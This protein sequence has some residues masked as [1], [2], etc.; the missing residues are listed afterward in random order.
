MFT[1]STFERIRI[2]DYTVTPFTVHKDFTVFKSEMSASGYT[3]RQAN[4]YRGNLPI[5]YKTVSVQNS[6]TSSD[7]TYN[8]INWRSIHNLYYSNPYDSVEG[9]EGY[10]QNACTKHLFLTASI[11]SAP[12]F[13]IGEGIKP[14]TLYLSS[15][16]YF[17]RDDKNNNLYDV[18]LTSRSLVDSTYLDAYWGFENLYPKTD[19]G[20]GTVQS[21]SFNYISNTQG[22]DITTVAHNVHLSPGVPVSGSNTGTKVDFITQGSYLFTRHVKQFNYET[23]ENFCISFWLK[24]PLSQSNTDSFTNTLINKNS[25][26]DFNVRI[27]RSKSQIDEYPNI[28][29][30][31][32]STQF[33]PIDIYPYKFEIVNHTSP[34]N[35]GRLK[36]TRSDGFQTVVLMSSASLNDGQY[37]HVC[38]NKSGSILTLYVD[39]VSSESSY[40]VPDQPTNDYH[41]I[42]GADSFS[43]LHQF[44]GSLDEVRFYNTT[45][46]P[47]QIS[48]TLAESTLGYLYQTPNVGNVF[49]RRGE[50]VLTSPIG[51]YHETFKNDNWKLQYKNNYTI[52]EFETLVRIKAGTYNKTMNPSALK[53][54]KSN[55]YLQDFTS[56]SLLPYVTTIGLYNDKLQLVAVGKL[57]RP[58][59]MR[60]DVDINVIV[61]WDY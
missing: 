61:R 1:P 35:V 19:K 27:D 12:F 33:R 44:S 50:V 16:E 7:G 15:S 18:R 24:A 25:Y 17:L 29:T 48:G 58:L 60:P 53:S 9:L 46:T 31:R 13:D 38:V 14:G 45:A 28:S 36:F 3:V 20:Y 52:Y 23:E 4:Y 47:T 2:D 6:P 11:I 43:G 22:E 26:A 30:S 10:N 8:Y 55:E 37:H 32:I 34:S 39:G 57:G 40:D 51:R 54:P 49:Y 56:G 21:H 42:F 59:K 41:L 5:G